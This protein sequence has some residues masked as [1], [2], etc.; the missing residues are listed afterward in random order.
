MG[1]ESGSLSFRLYRLSGRLAPE[2]ISEFARHVAPSLES[3]RRE[4]VSGWVGPRH[5]LD[6]DLSPENCLAGNLLR[7]TLLKAERKIPASLLRANCQLDEQAEMQSRGVP[8]LNRAT[9]REIRE[10]TVER[11]L[12]TM[13]PSLAGISAIF[14]LTQDLAYAGALS[15]KQQDAFATAFRQSS[16]MTAI[17]NTPETVALH[18]KAVN[19]RDLDPV[20]FSPAPDTVPASPGLGQE[21]LTWLWYFTEQSNGNL[22]REIAGGGEP[23]GLMIEGPLTFECEGRGAHEAILRH[24][25]P[26]ISNEAKAALTSG[27]KLRSAKLHLAQGSDQWTVL[28]DGR[29]FAFR[30]MKLPTCEPMDPASLLQ[31]RIRFLRRFLDIFFL[32]YERYLDVRRDARTWNSTLEDIRRWV[33][34]R[35]SCA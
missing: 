28:V 21:F 17:P 18:A 15:E 11:L 4:P 8:F 2:C 32:L 24:G 29:D 25:T 23:A 7:L 5:L 26:L 20:C 9:R 12:P 10:A 13:P 30:G 35:T 22:P 3:L 33:Q 31:E 34:D 1:F 19:I 14:D 27:K 16:G 6:R